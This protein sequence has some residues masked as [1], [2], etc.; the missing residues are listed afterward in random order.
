MAASL[1]EQES[2]LAAAQ[3]LPQSRPWA[4]W[5]IL[6]VSLLATVYGSVFAGAIEA[7]RSTISKPMTI[8][9]WNTSP[10][11]LP[12]PERTTMDFL[13]LP[14]LP[15]T[16]GGLAS[17]ADGPG[18]AGASKEAVQPRQGVIEYTVRDGDTLFGLAE[19]FGISANTIWWNNEL[20]DPDRLQIGQALIILPV[21][22]MLHTVKAGETTD[23]IA[24]RYGVELSE[25]VTAN[26][27]AN[28]NSLAV[29]QKLVIPGASPPADR[30]P[31]PTGRFIWPT[32]GQIT[33][34]FG[35]HGHQGLDIANNYGVSVVAADSGQVMATTALS[36]G[37]GWHVT[38]DHGNGYQTVYAHLSRFLVQPGQWV[39]RGQ[40]I[41]LIGTTGLSTG[42]HLHFEVHRNGVAVDPLR[43]LP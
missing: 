33:T 10:D 4:H 31:V 26:D 3:A 5:L 36:T 17:A 34:Y 39:Q 14:A 19:Q 9:F 8:T 24:S 23:A 27:L 11:T 28:P 43:L 22:G 25:I 41:G 42:P 7:K 30:R 15:K 20:A 1:I 35:E 13:A 2:L 32:Y 40:A 37:L 29:G 6:V 38:I 16:Q 21:S 18:L 12:Q